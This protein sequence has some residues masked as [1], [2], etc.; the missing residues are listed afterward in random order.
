MPSKE[1]C[2]LAVFMTEN[3]S[4][5]IGCH[6]KGIGDGQRLAASRPIFWLF[7]TVFWFSIGDILRV[8]FVRIL[9]RW[10]MSFL[11][12]SPLQSFSIGLTGVS[13]THFASH[14][15]AG[16]SAPIT[17]RT[18]FL[19][20]GKSPTA[21]Q[22]SLRCCIVT[23]LVAAMLMKMRVRTHKEGFKPRVGA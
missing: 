11:T 21:V 13:R 19:S 3:S 6:N 8:I 9:L 5:E 18:R 20:K 10:E 17:S 23:N 4:Q 7:N 16:S 22:Q 15:Q 12:H 1:D 2:Y 14:R